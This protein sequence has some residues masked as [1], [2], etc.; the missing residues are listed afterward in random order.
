MHQTTTITTKSQAE[1]LNR[2]TI[3]NYNP[4]YIEQT[5]SV[6]DDTLT[7]EIFQDT[8]KVVSR[9]ISEPVAETK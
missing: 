1:Q 5:I 6:E 4:N 9:K 8:L 7:K 2:W 3:T